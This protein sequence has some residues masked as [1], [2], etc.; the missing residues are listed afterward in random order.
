[1]R[2]SYAPSPRVFFV[3]RSVR[4]RT[5]GSP[6]GLCQVLSSITSTFVRSVVL[7]LD[8]C[9][10]QVIIQRFRLRFFRL[11][12]SCN[13]AVL[14]DYFARLAVFRVVFSICR[15]RFRDLPLANASNSAIAIP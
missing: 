4:L 11:S 9:L 12:F 5:T 10:R 6:S 3:R 7:P 13:G 15:L 2:L 14:E 1:M 8:I